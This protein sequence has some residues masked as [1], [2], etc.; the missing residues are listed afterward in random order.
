MSDLFDKRV[1]SFSD[2]EPEEFY[3]SR[4]ELARHV[5]T[6]P[7][8]H[9]KDP[10]W[11][12]TIVTRVINL[13][14]IDFSATTA[15]LEDVPD[16]VTYGK[17]LQYLSS[18]KEF[19]EKYL[20]RNQHIQKSYYASF[21]AAVSQPRL[22]V[23]S[24]DTELTIDTSASVGR[25]LV[26]IKPNVRARLIE[27]QAT[28]RQSIHLIEYL[29]GE[30]SDVI[31]EVISDRSESRRLVARFFTLERHARMRTTSQYTKGTYLRDE[32][33]I[34]LIGTQSECSVFGSHAVGDVTHAD[35]R[36]DITHD[37]LSTKSMTKYRYVLDG[38]ATG[39][40]GGKIHILSG[41]DKTEADMTTKS[42]LLSSD[43]KMYGEPQ[44]EIYTDDVQC[45]HGAS[46]G[47]IDEDALLYMQSRGLEKNEAKRELIESFLAEPLTL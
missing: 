34:N 40:F 8:P 4:K 3:A 37:A 9:T 44:L 18:E 36:I 2:N 45:T 26:L 21:A 35:T 41:A 31:H 23:V 28:G 12:H 38:S 19:L 24:K 14:T 47:T 13:A 7:L 30:N 20:T 17:A 29:I 39:I 16:G 33:T 32:I 46:T 10:Y 11:K 27:R 25:L 5:A 22:I 15:Y 1:A 6:A 43:T 42:I